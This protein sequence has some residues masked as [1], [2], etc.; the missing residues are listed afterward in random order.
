MGAIAF[1]DVL[2]LGT[3][4]ELASQRGERV[5]ATGVDVQPGPGLV[6]PIALFVDP[7]QSTG[8]A[9]NT[10]TGQT[11]NNVPLGSGP[12]LTTVENNRRMNVPNR[13]LAGNTT[14][15]YLSEDTANVGVN[16]RLLS[17]AGFNLDFVGG[18]VPLDTGGTITT[19]TAIDSSVADGGQRERL[20]VS[21]FTDWTP[22]IVNVHSLGGTSPVF[23]R[24][25]DLTRNA[26]AWVASQEVGEVTFGHLSQPTTED[27]AN[28]SQFVVADAFRIVRPFRLPLEMAPTP[29][30][31]GG[32]L[33]SFTNFQIHATG[34]TAEQPSTFFQP[35]PTW[36]QCSFDGPLLTG[37][38][39]NGCA[40]ED[41][42]QG[43]FFGG[44]FA[45]VLLPNGGTD[46]VV[47]ALN[48]GGNL[49]V[50]GDSS[51]TIGATFYQTVFIFSV[52]QVS[53]F[54]G[55]QIQSIANGLPGCNY[56]QGATLLLGGLMWGN[57]NTAQGLLV[58]PGASFI[59][60]VFTPNLF[61]STPGTNDFAFLFNNTILTQ[62]RAWDDSVGAY[63]TLRTTSWANYDA[64]IAGGGFAHN[65]HCVQAI[66]G[67]STSA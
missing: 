23:T 56:D 44:F 41:G 61:G 20:Q 4:I 62:A 33:V 54:D 2:G 1:L 27:G 55:I 8:F 7:Q 58:N 16:F 64:A 12:I 17:L 37:G 65:A 9:S 57:G 39:F 34:N 15:A 32:G 3:S 51:F 30:T 63:T 43:L 67:V 21:D 50:T 31:S 18:L 6:P 14:I 25:Q 40:F 26:T 49:Y 10:N 60:E 5:V 28:F 52:S 22:F 47:G 46:Q 11:A 42:M 48:I 19:V 13:S 36:T 53:P 66:A 45:G 24:V 38:Q 29:L 59:P 35:T